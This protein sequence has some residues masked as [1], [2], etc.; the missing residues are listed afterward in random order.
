MEEMGIME[1]TQNYFT[2]LN[3]INV[4]D[5]VKEKENLSYLS[6]GLGLGV[7]SK[8]YT[9]TQT[10]KYMKLKQAVFIGLTEKLVG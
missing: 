9:P 4:N 1:K 6:A 7:K 5:K 10:I 8:K 2:E 3:N